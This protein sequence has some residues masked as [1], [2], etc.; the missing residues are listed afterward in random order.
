MPPSPERPLLTLAEVAR[1]LACSKRT[2]EAWASSG[3]LPVLRLSRG[4][5][6]VAPADLAAFLAARREE[7]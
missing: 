6:R 7:A 3:R 2:V 5:V 1:A 4:I